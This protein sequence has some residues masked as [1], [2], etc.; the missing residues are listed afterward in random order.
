MQSKAFPTLH[1]DCVR[2]WLNLSA[3]RCLPTWAIRRTQI[4]MRRGLCAKLPIDWLYYQT[5]ILILGRHV[6]RLKKPYVACCKRSKGCV[7]CATNMTSPHMGEMPFLH[8]CHCDRR[9]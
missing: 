1:S 4:G 2:R 5:V 6:T 7:N 3:R 8:V 9:R